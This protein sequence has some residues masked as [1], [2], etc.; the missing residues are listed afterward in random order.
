MYQV[1][2]M[3]LLVAGTMYGTYHY[4][5]YVALQVRMSIASAPTFD[6]ALS[7]HGL[8]LGK[9]MLGTALREATG[10]DGFFGYLLYKAQQGMSIGKFYSSNRLNLGFVLTWVYWMLEF[11]IIL[12][13]TIRIGKKFV[14]SLCEFCGNFYGSEKHLGGTTNTNESLVLDLIKQRDFVEL[15]K[16]IEKNA[17]VPS[18]ELYFRGCSGCNKSHS[19]LVL[20]QVFQGARG[21]LQFTDRSKIVLQPQESALL[22][23]QLNFIG[24]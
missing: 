17:E 13:I 19:H 5:R 12:W 8:A 23:S 4:G 10:H 18:L 9:M 22:L 11:G 15:G 2:L 21:S 6:E 3:S 1:I 24:N 14:A 16:L 7:D 20:R